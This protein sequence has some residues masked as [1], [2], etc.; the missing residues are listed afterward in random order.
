MYLLIVRKDNNN[1]IERSE[2]MLNVSTAKLDDCKTKEEYEAEKERLD[3][4]IDEETERKLAV[5][6]N[7]RGFN[8]W[9]ACIIDNEF[10][11]VSEYDINDSFEEALKKA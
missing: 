8:V 4:L 5:V 3:I 2:T 7:A 6:H 10:V 11:L 1:L 9:T